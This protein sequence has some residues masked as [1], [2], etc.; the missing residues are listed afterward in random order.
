[1]SPICLFIAL[2][3]EFEEYKPTVDAIKTDL[4]ATKADLAATK[5]ALATAQGTI[6]Y[7]GQVIPPPGAIL[8]W[9]S[10]LDPNDQPALDLAQYTGNFVLSINVQ[11]STNICSFVQT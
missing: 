6:D 7:H 4:E 1:M 10:K 8:G 5:E 11:N 2:K 3:Q 9:V